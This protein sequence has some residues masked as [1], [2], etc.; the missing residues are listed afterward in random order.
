MPAPGFLT[1]QASVETDADNRLLQV[2]AESPDFYRS[3]QIQLDGA[4]APRVKVIEFRNLPT[5]LYQVTGTL[6]GTQGPRA[7]VLRIA[8]VAPT[9]GSVR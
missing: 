4:N 7:T 6:I 1:V 9:G 5:G 3:S 8:N 2:V